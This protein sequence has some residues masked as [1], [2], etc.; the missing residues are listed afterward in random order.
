MY[1]LL[2]PEINQLL[3]VYNNLNR[4]LI[5]SPLIH[6]I[7]TDFRISGLHRLHVCS[8]VDCNNKHS[9][10]RA[11]RQN[12]KLWGHLGRAHRVKDKRR[13]LAVNAK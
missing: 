11:E 13:T 2:F 4:A 8:R 3:L 9:G 6:L 12:C 7:F 10:H 1:S 5:S